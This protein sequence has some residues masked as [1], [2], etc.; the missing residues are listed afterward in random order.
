[1]GNKT[2][3][4][5]KGIQVKVPTSS[6]HGYAFMSYTNSYIYFLGCNGYG[7]STSYGYGWYNQH[8]MLRID[9][10]YVKDVYYGVRNGKQ[11]PGITVSNGYSGT[12][13]PVIGLYA[14]DANMHAEGSLPTGSS[15]NTSVVNAEIY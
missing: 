3:I 1:M 12:A 15:A 4:A 9:R 5:A 14:V 10:F 7:T 8:S 11:S 6:E 2:P 13:Q